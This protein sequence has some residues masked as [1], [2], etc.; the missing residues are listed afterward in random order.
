MIR[1]VPPCPCAPAYEVDWPALLDGCPWLG[2]LAGCVDDPRFHGE[3]DVLAHT[4]MVAEELVRLAG[5]RALP[6]PQRE[7]LFAAALLHDLG[8]PATRRVDPDG[9]IGTPGHA[10][11]GSIL[12]RITLWKRD[13]PFEVREEIAA[14]VRHHMVPGHLL[15]RDRPERRAI[16]VSQVVR[17]DLL[18]L[19]AEADA[20]GR[21]CDDR[22]RLLDEVELFRDCCRELGCY[23]G[24]RRFGCA[25][26]RYLYFTSLDRHPDAPAPE[27]FVT[28]VVVMSGL[29]GAG[30]DTWIRKNLAG[31]PVV[32]LDAIRQRM[33]IR[34]TAPQGPIRDAARKLAKEHLRARRP[35]VWN[36]TN[37][38]R[39]MRAECIGLF[40]N[41]GARVRIVYVEAGYEQLGQQNS[42]R[43]DEVPGAVIEKLLERWEVPDV[44]EAHQ[45]DWI[46]APASRAPPARGGRR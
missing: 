32:S 35:F 16:E 33:G 1:G 22:Q 10:R 25:S 43:R 44:T 12:T 39:Q 18:S 28:E 42:G 46:V 41:Y 8:K 15:Q 30:K 9:R 38:S 23:D 37:V 36:A 13:V 21:K 17:C 5:W 14:L 26:A 2:E 45:V 11:R 4:R 20:L 31:W 24:P 40:A 29:P 34:P 3:E 7:S 27:G 6:E 19:L